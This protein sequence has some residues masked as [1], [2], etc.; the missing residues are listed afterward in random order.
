MSHGGQAVSLIQISARAIA[1]DYAAPQSHIFTEPGRPDGFG[2]QS[3]VQC[4][5]TLPEKR[6][7]SFRIVPPLRWRCPL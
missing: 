1:E 4:A 6:G 5:C 2:A 3:H 7:L